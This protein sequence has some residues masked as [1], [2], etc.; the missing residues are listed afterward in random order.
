[1]I[2]LSDVEAAQ[3]R[4]R[5]VAKRTPLIYAES[6]SQSAGH[7]VY[8]KAENLQLGGAFKLRGAYNKI[9]S[10]S[11]AERRRGVVAHS[12]GNHAI[13]V[14]Y[15]SKLLGVKAVIV[16]PEN[17][18]ETKI[19]ITRSYGAE[20]VRCGNTLNDREE[21]T[22]RLM[23][24]HGYV[25][26]HPFNDPLI[27]A[28]Q[29]TAGLEIMDDLPTVQA[30][31]TPVGGGGLVSGVAT[32]VKGRNPAVKVYGVEPQGAND[33]WRSLREGHLVTIDHPDT[34]ADGLR[35]QHLGALTYEVIKAR[36]DD[37]VL[38]SDEEILD[39]VKLL[40]EKEHLVVEP[41]GAV[42]AAALRLRR[43]GPLSGPAVAV[44]SGGNI[45]PSLLKSLV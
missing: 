2:T 44:L 17:A 38:V 12:S 35:S 11:D 42:A 31:L 28:G 13:A 24:Q 7:A 19:K 41:S 1:M 21:T 29:G 30:V 8:L 15:A 6:L 16:I 23:E 45:E 4:L 25:L 14:A 22:R 33:A 40:L 34:V 20:V 5:P 27:M 37:I 9:S 39:T 26:V 10:L 32:A 3:V 18:V 43:I 36:V